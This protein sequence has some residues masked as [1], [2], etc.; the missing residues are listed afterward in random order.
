MKIIFRLLAIL[1]VLLHSGC[2]NMSGQ[3]FDVQKLTIPI[4][5]KEF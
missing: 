2:T 5:H 3:H 1:F 4:Y